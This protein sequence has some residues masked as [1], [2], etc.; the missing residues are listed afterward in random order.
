MRSRRDQVDAHNNM[1]SRLTGAL[2]RAE[3]DIL[4]SPTRRD[5]RGLAYGVV[6]GILLLAV[7]AVWALMSGRGSTAWRQPGTLIIDKGSG[8]RFLLVDGVLRP[9]RNI[10]SARLL[11]GGAVRPAVV[12][13]SRLAGTPRGV[14]LGIQDGPDTRPSPST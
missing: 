2:V 10:A 13:S 6:A 4:D 9:T 7:V 3:P 11:T 14:P 1:V 5:F 12:P 8:S